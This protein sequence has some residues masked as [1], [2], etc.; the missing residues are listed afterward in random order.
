MICDEENG[1]KSPTFDIFCHDSGSILINAMNDCTASE[2]EKIRIAVSDD[3]GYNWSVERG[4]KS[5]LNKNDL[6]FVSMCALKNEW[7]WKFTA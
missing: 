6:I 1:S 5:N 4:R 3:V 2:Y 7:Q